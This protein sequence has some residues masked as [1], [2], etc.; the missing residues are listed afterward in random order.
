V[1]IKA[2]KPALLIIVLVANPLK[3]VPEKKTETGKL[4]ITVTDNKTPLQYDDVANYDKYKRLTGCQT[5]AQ[6]KAVI[7]NIPAG[8]YSF[9]MFI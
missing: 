2:N 8:T 7:L 3:P 6:G 1:K 4:S 9:K 5:D